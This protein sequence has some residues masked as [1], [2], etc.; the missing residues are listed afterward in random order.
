MQITKGQLRQYH[1]NYVHFVN[2]QGEFLQAYSDEL[3]LRFLI[4]RFKKL[5]HVEFDAGFGDSEPQSINGLLELSSL[6]AV[7]QETLVERRQ[8]H[9]FTPS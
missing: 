1:Q 5:V 8:A 3:E 2:A 4:V 7:A 9:I 6:S